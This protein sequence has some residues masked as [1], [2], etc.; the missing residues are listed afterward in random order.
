MA[1]IIAK[2][3]SSDLRDATRKSNN[4]STPEKETSNLRDMLH[5]KASQKLQHKTP[6]TLSL[7]H[8]NP[9]AYEAP[10]DNARRWSRAVLPGSFSHCASP[11]RS[12]LW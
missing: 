2:S 6:Q 3:P 12:L 9:K 5:V 8:L 10:P 7:K 11:D 1:A 4:K